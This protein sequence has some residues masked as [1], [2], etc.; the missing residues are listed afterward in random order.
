V[1]AQIP[2]QVAFEAGTFSLVG[3]NGGPLF[4]PKALGI[5]PVSMHTGCYRGYVAGYDVDGDGRFT[6]ARLTPGSGAKIGRRKIDADATIAGR[7]ARPSKDRGEYDFDGLNLPIPFSGGLLVADRFIPA[8]YRHMGFQPGWKYEVVF[9][10]LLEAGQLIESHDRS[11][12]VAAVRDQ[13]VSEHRDD[14]E[15]SRRESIRRTFTLDYDRTL[16]G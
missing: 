4:D 12:D 13:V 5:K 9:E 6:L 1:T 14:A 3:V 11:V 2:D 16:H 7:A 15:S 8:L 10:L